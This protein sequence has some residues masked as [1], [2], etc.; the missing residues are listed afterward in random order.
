MTVYLSWPHLLEAQQGYLLYLGNPLQVEGF[1]KMLH[2][3][4][5][6]NQHSLGT[7]INEH[8]IVWLKIFTVVGMEV[9]V[10]E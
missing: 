4:F 10:I 8:L 1:S 9:G 7:C 6:I 2:L 5:I 3:S